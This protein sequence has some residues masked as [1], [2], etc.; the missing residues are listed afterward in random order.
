MVCGIYSLE[1]LMGKLLHVSEI[2]DFSAHP[3]T[4]IT[5]PNRQGRPLRVAAASMEAHGSA[6]AH[7][8]LKQTVALYDDNLMPSSVFLLHVYAPL[9]F[10]SFIPK[11]Y[12]IQIYRKHHLS[13]LMTKFQDLKTHNIYRC[14]QM[15]D[16][17]V[18]RC[19]RNGAFWRTYFDE[20]WSASSWAPR[21]P[22]SGD[23][24]Y[25]TLQDL[26]CSFLRKLIKE[27]IKN[28]ELTKKN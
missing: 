11:G 7:P 27:T 8:D 10:S 13:T 23:Y 22:Y 24:S 21:I 26:E 2:G 12:L 25:S 4:L 20:S 14:C 17:C 3:S 9:E 19:R 15:C 28:K 16:N 6:R 18:S 1:A 5:D